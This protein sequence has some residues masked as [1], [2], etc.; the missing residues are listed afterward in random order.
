MQNCAFLKIQ[1]DESFCSGENF[2]PK[3]T[4]IYLQSVIKFP[5]V[6]LKQKDSF[7]KRRHYYKLLKVYLAFLL[8]L[9]NVT[10]EEP[11]LVFA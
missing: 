1:S 5:N 4:K 7:P 11:Q 2:E 8:F 3:K 10:F 6:I 9:I